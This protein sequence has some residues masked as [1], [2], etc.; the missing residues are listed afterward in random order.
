MIFDVFNGDADGICALHQLRLAQPRSSRLISGVKRD[1]R[2]VR[3][4]VSEVGPGRKCEPETI[5]TVLDV[6]MD[7]NKKDLLA[8]LEMD[9]KVFYVDH[10]FPGEIPDSESLNAHVDTDPDVCTSLIIDRLFRG[11][12]RPWAVVAAF[13]D[14]LHGAAMD[15]AADL[16]LTSDQLGRLRELGELMNYNGYGKSVSD[17]YF[18]PQLLY[19][20]VKPYEDPLDFC[21]QSDVPAI[22]RHGFADDMTKAGNCKPFIHRAGIR[23]FEFPAESWSRRVAG[24]FSNK[25][26]REMKETAHA[27]IIDNSDG[28]YLVSV[29]APLCNKTGADV[30]CRAY[31]TGGGRAAAAGINAL[32]VDLLKDF[33]NSFEKAFSS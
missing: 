14:N 11:R 23:A 13:G 19:E 6:S 26:A 2:L 17:L 21:N 33:M 15:A 28:T 30:L 9:C 16:K 7:S 5:I 20:A 12:Y 1:I 25:K 24:V 10:H 27:L 22:L 32:P 4:V 3:Q 8:L 31:P 18:T 29:R